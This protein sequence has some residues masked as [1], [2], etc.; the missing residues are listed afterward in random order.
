MP[1][2]RKKLNF[3]FSVLILEG[4]AT[5]I[6]AAVT[7]IGFANLPIPK[8]AI[9]LGMMMFFNGYWGMKELQEFKKSG[10]LPPLKDEDL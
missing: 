7:M 10:G 6:S 3:I 1:E 5:G 2:L 9:F 4:V 8:L